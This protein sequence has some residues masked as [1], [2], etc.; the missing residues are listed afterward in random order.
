ME[1]QTGENSGGWVGK[2]GG[3]GNTDRGE[4]R[5]I[6]VIKHQIKQKLNFNH[7]FL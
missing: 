5:D 7:T 3:G 6:A 1:I 4:F 2:V